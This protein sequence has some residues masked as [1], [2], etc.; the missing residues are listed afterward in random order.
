[1]WFRSNEKL[2]YYLREKTNSTFLSKG[3]LGIPGEL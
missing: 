2:F 1:M 3:D